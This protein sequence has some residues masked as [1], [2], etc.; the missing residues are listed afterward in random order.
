ME[1]CKLDSK[2]GELG[3]DNKTKSK[4]RRNKNRGK[5]ILDLTFSSISKEMKPWTLKGD[6]NDSDTA[7]TIWDRPLVDNNP[8]GINNRFDLLM[9]LKDKSTPIQ[10]SEDIALKLDMRDSE[11]K[12]E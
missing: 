6:Q 5:E 9:Q 3:M 4:R 7:M 10:I 12:V 11:N 8:T 2:H 1:P